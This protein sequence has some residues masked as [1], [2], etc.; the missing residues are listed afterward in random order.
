MPCALTARRSNPNADAKVQRFL[1]LAKLFNEK[2]QENTFFLQKRAEGRGYTLLY[3]RGLGDFV[4][5]V[6]NG[7]ASQL[8]SAE[9]H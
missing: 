3:I 1:E 4:G 9:L 7:K 2:F 5:A 6:D 8:R